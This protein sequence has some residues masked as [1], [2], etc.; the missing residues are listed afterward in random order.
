MRYRRNDRVLLAD[1]LDADP[2]RGFVCECF[3]PNRVDVTIEGD[4]AQRLLLFADDR[5]LQLD[6]PHALFIDGLYVETFANRPAAQDY[7]NGIDPSARVTVMATR[8]RCSGCADD[9]DA[10]LDDVSAMANIIYEMTSR[11]PTDVEALSFVHECL[12]CAR[13]EQK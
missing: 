5:R 1:E 4:P 12:A 3:T 2:R 13:T 10:G 8:I 9:F 6:D 11:E 7:G